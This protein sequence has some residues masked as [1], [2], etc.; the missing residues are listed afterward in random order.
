MKLSI[1]IF[2]IVALTFTNSYLVDK[3]WPLPTK[4]SYNKDGD[5]ITASPCNLR[6]V[7]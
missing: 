2:V 1:L 4:Y 5:N 3:L 7:V 6:Y